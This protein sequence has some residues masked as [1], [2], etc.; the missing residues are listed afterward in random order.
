MP[1]KNSGPS[2]VDFFASLKAKASNAQKLAEDGANGEEAEKIEML[3]LHQIQP[4]PDQPRRA[5]TPEADAE[6]AE[7]IKE[8]GILQPI[9]VRRVNDHYELVA[10]ERRS[11]AAQMAGLTTIP[12]IVKNYSDKEARTVAAIENLQRQDLEELDEARYFQFLAAEYNL[13]N[14]DIAQ[15]I[16]KSPSY[17][18]QRMRALKVAEENCVKNTQKLQTSQEGEPPLKLWKYRAKDWE[19]FRST[20]EQARANA[21]QVSPQER[22]ILLQSVQ[23]LKQELAR[24][25]NHLRNE[26]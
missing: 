4:N 20:V 19:K 17:V 1:K 22:E 2:S 6:L 13:S 11:R 18:D 21:G 9:I 16:H 7:D 15:L 26:E 8:R 24:L 23:E 25:E 14:R 5:E 12:A 3:P 10:G